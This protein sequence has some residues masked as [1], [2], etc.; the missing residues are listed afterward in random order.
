MRNVN[1][2]AAMAVALIL[3]A[4]VAAPAIAGEATV[5]RFVQELAKVKNLNATEPAIAADSLR[6]VGIR[7]PGK[8][9][10]DRRLTEADVAT[11]S[12][13][14]GLLVTTSNPNA[15]FDDQKVD[16]FFKSF[17]VELSLGGQ[18]GD[19]AGTYGD[20]DCAP[21]D[22]CTNPGAGDPGHGGEVPPGFDPFT[23]GRGKARG[24]SKQSRTPTDPE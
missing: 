4:A 19:G 14:A 20:D 21:G 8:L 23:K 1:R 5:G 7:L 16:R 12:R 6:A 24:K 17:S 11:I 22:D 13:A 18:E 15:Y 10:F 9:E 2:L 3:M